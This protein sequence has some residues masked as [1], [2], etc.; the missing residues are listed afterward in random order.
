MKKA[1]V[2]LLIG[3]LLISGCK[4]NEVEQKVSEVITV[5]AKTSL[6]DMKP[7]D[8]SEIETT[9]DAG[10]ESFSVIT[11]GTG[12]P[13][14]SDSQASA[15]TLIQ[16]NGG[17]Y[18]VDCGD[19]SNRNLLASDFS[20]KDLRA[21]LF[22]HHHIDH[23]TDFFDIYSKSFLSND[24]PIDIIGPPRTEKFVSFLS[25]VYLD[26]LL[27]RKSNIK[28]IDES[29]KDVI[30]NYANTSEVID[31]GHF[32][33]DGLD[34]EAAEM[35]HTMYNLAYRFEADDKSIVVS[36]DVS[37]DENLIE[38]AKDA[39][40]L[41]I[42]GALYTEKD[43]TTARNNMEPFY[44]YGG[45]FD[46]E[47][48]LTFDEMVE[49]AVKSNVSTLVV[50]H[51]NS[52]DQD[53]ISRSINKIKETFDG[54][55]I[56][57]RDMLEIGIEAEE[58]INITEDTPKDISMV[59]NSYNIVDTN[60]VEFYS[61]QNKIESPSI[62][63][64]FYGQDASYT[65]NTPA[66]TDNKD[67]T[68]S[69]KITGLMWAQDMGEKMS[70]DEAVVF[71]N[72]S[73]LGGYD[74]WRIPT[75]KELYSL[76]QFDG[77]VMGEKATE[78]LFIDTDYF[79]QPLGDTSSGERE[80]DAQTWSSTKYVGTTMRGDETI[81][82][83]NFVDG[84]IKGYPTYI[85]RTSTD[86]AM[87]FRLV[88]GN[89]AYGE[90]NFVDNGDGTITDLA[91]GLTWQQNDSGYGMDWGAALDYAE[92]LDYAGYDDWRLPN[93]KELQ[94]IV[95]YT[96]SL[97]TTDS[98]AIDELFNTSSILDINGNTNYPYFWTSTSHLDGVNPYSYGVYFAFGEALGVMN[99]T[100]MDVHGA[101]AQR[102]DPK[103]GDESDYPSTFGPQGDIRMV[104]NYVRCVRND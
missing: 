82:G 84:R 79:N 65:G 17:Y 43:N 23:T 85:K 32:V 80:I 49:I 50:T 66:Y 7:N 34:I 73:N 86:N 96:R 69:D 19:G 46:V 20:F 18:L 13:K 30:L 74:D 21:I 36:G 100:L 42:D 48:H 75:I 98:A 15:S 81:F 6:E 94:S 29:Y 67:G 51:Y 71:A 11:V 102:S 63:E 59:T 64:E 4:T 77:R 72:N 88:R 89:T 8:K 38:F 45:N 44:E 95:D 33:I 93:A 26:D 60:Q 5:D 55:V 78:N 53:R 41:V 40:I 68:I 1:I 35:T 37:Y 3:M 54:E 61:D 24:A 92:N 2:I 31:A 28:E 14:Y 57:A 16:Y 12:T 58:T 101:G 52:T 70:Y 25:D 87:Y 47:A 103:S 76:I 83:V 104:Y 39:D 91:T 99:D 27:Y 56:Y 22:T 97:Q 62:G 9:L 90:N 10:K